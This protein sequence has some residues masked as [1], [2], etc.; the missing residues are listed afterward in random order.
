MVGTPME[1]WAW[2]LFSSDFTNLIQDAV[3]RYGIISPRTSKLLHLTTR[4]LRYTFATNRVREGISAREL[5]D[6]LDH[7][8]LQHVRV[9]FDARST[10]VERLDRAAAMAIAPMLKLFKGRTVKDAESA[11]QG[12]DPAKRIRIIPE[13]IDQNHHDVRPRLCPIWQRLDRGRGVSG[14]SGFRAFAFFAG[15][16]FAGAV[17]AGA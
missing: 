15:A 17:F 8:D 6:A 11:S 5:A 2:H 12:N 14:N 10:V 4:R 9:Y 7:T 1:P 13:L 16:V 3:E